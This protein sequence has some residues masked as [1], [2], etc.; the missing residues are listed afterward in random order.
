MNGSNKSVRSIEIVEFFQRMTFLRQLTHCTRYV[1]TVISWF[2][3]W[4]EKFSW[5]MGPF[6]VVG[7]PWL[8]TSPVRGP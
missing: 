3:Y 8:N 6:P 2:K 4:D 1:S 7:C 5:Q